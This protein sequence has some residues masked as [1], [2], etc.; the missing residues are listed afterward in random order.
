MGHGK[1]FAIGVTLIRSNVPIVKI[2]CLPIGRRLCFTSRSLK[3]FGLSKVA[4]LNSSTS[5]RRL[6]G[7]SMHLP[8]SRPHGHFIV[9]TSHSRLAPRARACVNRVGRRC[10]RM[11]LVSDKDSVGVYLITRKGTSM[12]PHFT[13]AV[14]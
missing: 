2:V 7:F 4:T 5:L 1:R 14:R 9:M 12:C 13:P 8:V 6:V 10:R 11:R 3:T